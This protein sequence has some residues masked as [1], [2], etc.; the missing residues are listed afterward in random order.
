MFFEFFTFLKHIDFWERVV[1]TT[2][3]WTRGSLTKH[4]SIGHVARPTLHPNYHG[5]DTPPLS[6]CPIRTQWI[7][8]QTRVLTASRSQS[9]FILPKA[10]STGPSWVTSGDLPPPA[11]QPTEQK[12]KDGGKSS[13]PQ[14]LT[15]TCRIMMALPPSK[16]HHDKPKSF[17]TIKGDKAP[18][19]I[20]GSH[21][22]K[23]GKHS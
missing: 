22:V 13:L 15:V 19:T 14:S 18:G 10:C 11:L 16:H 6:G 3:K 5:T 21:T 2:P 9:L 12:D 4:S 1:R 8:S 20:K 7:A 23:K 17:P